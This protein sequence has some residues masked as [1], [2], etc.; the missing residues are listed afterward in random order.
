M[1]I[2]RGIVP[3]ATKTQKATPASPAKKNLFPIEA[4]EKLAKRME[5]SM[6]VS[7][8]IFLSEKK[9]NCSAGKMPSLHVYH[10]AQ[11]FFDPSTNSIHI[12]SH[13]PVEYFGVEDELTYESGL[14]F[15]MG[16]ENEHVFSTATVPY[17]KGIFRGVQVIIEQIARIEGINKRFRNEKDYDVFVR[18][19][20][21]AKNIYINFNTLAQLVGHIMNSVEDGRIERLRSLR[22]PGFALQ[23]RYFRGIEWNQ[24]IEYVPYDK[25][26]DEAHLETLITAIHSLA[27]KNLFPKGF[28]MQYAG[29]PIMD[30]MLEI[31]P[32]VAQA[33][34]AGKTRRMADN[35]VKIIEKLAPLIY[36]IYKKNAAAEEALAEMLKQLLSQLISSLDPD[37]MHQLSEREEGEASEEECPVFEGMSDLVITLDDETFDKL[38]EQAKQDGKKGPGVMVRREHPKDEENKDDKDGKGNGNGK[39]SDKKD[40]KDNSSANSNQKSDEKSDEKGEGSGQEGES[41]DEK[42]NASSDANNSNS[43]SSQSSNSDSAPSLDETHNDTTSSMKPP[44]EEGS[45][46]RGSGEQGGSIEDVLEAMKEAAE[47]CREESADAINIINRASVSATKTKTPTIENTDKPLTESDVKD[48]MGRI[49]FEEVTRKYKLDKH[50]PSVL[51]ARARAFRKKNERYFKSLSTPNVTNL[52]SGGVD[53]S[54]IYGLTFGETNVFR[55]MGQDKKFDGCVYMLLDNSGSTMGA[56]RME[57][58]KAAAVVEEGFKGLLPLKIVAFDYSG[59]VIHEVIKGWDESQKMNCCYNFAMHGRNGCGNCDN[60]DIDIAAKELLARPERKKLLIVLSDGAPADSEATRKAIANA[61]KKG[62]TVFGIYF[63]QGA[64]GAQAN[65]F[66]KMYEKDYVCV[67]ADQIDDTLTKLMIKFSRS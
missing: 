22:Y 21:R 28:I 7:N 65:T 17:Q 27:T 39:K 24:D 50:L 5:P 57:E 32:F 35:V 33:V 67:P 64:I 42:S 62:I 58:C 14:K 13:G 56:K 11:Q 60:Y 45:G 18:T 31:M 20:L 52:S 12:G 3:M 48:I 1:N 53:P 40:G 43:N 30:E 23:R 59:G 47:K 41:S 66:K 10:D 19:D 55:K 54:L 44:S 6:Q 9:G 61:R 63:E 34:L 25:M 2:E 49:H 37:K 8:H 26:T 16:H 36:T 38:Q 4:A 46:S 15:L 51:N 29:T